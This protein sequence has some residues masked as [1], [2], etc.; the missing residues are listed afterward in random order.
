MCIQNWNYLDE[1]KLNIKSIFSIYAIDPTYGKECYLRICNWKEGGAITQPHARVRCVYVI[2]NIDFC[3]YIRQIFS[4]DKEIK[5]YFYC[6]HFKINVICLRVIISN[7]IS[8]MFDFF[9]FPCIN[10]WTNRNKKIIICFALRH[11]APILG[12][13]R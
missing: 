6:I 8:K 4:N 10:A 13:W 5:V 11:M 3:C 12:V 2:V 9:S 1:N 7:A